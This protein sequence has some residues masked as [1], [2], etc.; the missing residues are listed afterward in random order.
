MSVVYYS[1]SQPHDLESL[2]AFLQILVVV[3]VNVTAISFLP[4][5]STL[6]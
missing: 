4:L 1:S 6:F 5:F 3:G 2:A